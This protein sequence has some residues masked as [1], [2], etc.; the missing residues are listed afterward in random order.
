MNGLPRRDFLRFGLAAALCG[1]AGSDW[2]QEVDSR[3]PQATEPN[4]I[5]PDQ[6]PMGWAQLPSILAAIVPPQFPDRDFVITDFGA[7]GTDANPALTAAIRACHQAGGGRVVIPAGIWY[8]NG[9]VHLLSNVNLYLE[10]N[11]ILIFPFA[12]SAYLPVQRVRWQGIR[13]YNY[14]PLIYAY[15][16]RNIAITGSGRIDGNG[17]RW[18]RW[19]N[20]QAPDWLLLQKMARTG[21]PVEQRI[22]GAGHR[23]RPS[24]FEVSDCQNIL[25]QGVTFGGS[26]FWT[27]HP[28]FCTNVTF[29]GVTVIPGGVQN[30][31]GCD[32]DSCQNVLI[33]GC[34]FTTG[35]DNVSIKAGFNLDAEGLPG[36]ANIVIQNCNCLRSD[37]SGL[38]LGTDVASGIR[39]VFIQNCT[40]NHCLHAHYI[41]ARGDWGGSVENVYIRSNQVGTCECLLTLQP[42]CYHGPGPLGPPIYS[43]INMQDVTCAESKGAAFFFSGDP[44]LPIDEVN[45]AN[46]N[47]GHAKSV[48]SIEN[49]TGLTG[50]DIVVNGKPIY[51]SKSGGV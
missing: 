47:V 45:L 1:A 26:P 17:W 46:I 16:Q 31:D 50:N 39:N 7:S 22:F 18:A 25:V 37:W 6:P 24:L 23:L 41:K 9:P 5:H 10:K 2:A 15:G 8:S 42:D 40:V 43:N 44:R 49:T 20:Q 51:L 19:A 35:D 21:V 28:V 34:N 48:A 12:P 27:L 30:D 11:S 4:P 38:T 33:E 14:S 13:C 32:P 3:D 29:Q 36:C